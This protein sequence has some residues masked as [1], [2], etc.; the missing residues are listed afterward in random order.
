MFSTVLAKP[1]LRHQLLIITILLSVLGFF[2]YGLI[3]GY[4]LLLHVC[5]DITLHQ[6]L[7][8]YGFLTGII[9]V[10]LANQLVVPVLTIIVF[11]FIEWEN[12]SLVKMQKNANEGTLY[13]GRHWLK[14]PAFDLAFRMM[15]VVTGYSL[16]TFFSSIKLQLLVLLFIVVNASISIYRSKRPGISLRKL[17]E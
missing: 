3:R 16:F 9:H 11:Y 2:F 14:D 5:F 12:T 7:E 1:K 13:K 8:D 15:S 10:I 4:A 6:Y 17:S